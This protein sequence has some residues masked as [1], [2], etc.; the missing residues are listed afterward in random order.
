M[1]RS[2]AAFCMMVSFN[3]HSVRKLRKDTDHPLHLRRPSLFPLYSSPLVWLVLLL[4]VR[5]R[6]VVGAGSGLALGV[7]G[8]FTF[9]CFR[10]GPD[11][12]VEIARFLYSQGSRQN[13]R[14]SW[15]T[16]AM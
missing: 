7:D 12:L 5:F 3:N 2:Y 16:D 13:R 8:R 4:L 9:H 1:A 11:H 10:M 15:F 6:K 14:Q